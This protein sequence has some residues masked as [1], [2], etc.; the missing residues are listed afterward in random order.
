MLGERVDSILVIIVLLVMNGND[1]KRVEQYKKKLLY[2]SLI[3]LF[4]LAIFVRAN[5]NSLNAL[6][7][8]VYSQA[9]ACDGLYVYLCSVKHYVQYGAEYSV[10]GNLFFG[11]FPGVFYGA[12][13]EYNYTVFLNNHI[14]PNVGGGLFFSEGMLAFGPLGVVLYMVLMAVLIKY[15][16]KHKTRLHY[17]IFLLFMIIISRIIWYGFIYTYKPAILCILFILF[18]NTSMKHSKLL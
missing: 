7:V 15:L 10:L 17:T 1:I 14:A 16:F 8:S 9:T 5:E 2:L 12:I 4:A 13:S 18:F 6:L 11:L 3:C